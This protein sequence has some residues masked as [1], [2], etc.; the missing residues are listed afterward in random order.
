MNRTANSESIP[1]KPISDLQ[2]FEAT[3]GLTVNGVI[4]GERTQGSLNGVVIVNGR[5]SKATVSGSLLGEIVAQV[6][7]ALVSLFTPST[8]D[9]YKVPEGAYIVV[10]G[11]FPMC[12]KPK[13]SKATAVLD[14]LNPES[15]LM[16]V[17]NSDVARGKLVGEEVVNGRTVQHYIINGEAFLAA[18]QNST[19]P[20]LRAFGRGL[21][22]ADDAHL[23]LDAAGGY[24]VA[25]SG[26]YRGAYEPLK[27]QGELSVQIAL[28]GVNTN[29]PVNLPASCA[30]PVI[31]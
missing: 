9:L 2:S 8:V 25:F 16:M 19:D 7:G 27:F 4:N 10:N 6:G 21:W 23:Y 17:T 26:S 30:D 13:A 12:V 5:N 24:P 28:T 1:I 31:V 20:K 3:V 18:A 11:L 14:E 15:L 22:S 29:K